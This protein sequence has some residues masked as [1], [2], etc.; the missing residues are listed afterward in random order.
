MYVAASRPADIPSVETAPEPR[1]W[2]LKLFLLSAVALTFPWVGFLGY[3]AY[4]FA[5]SIVG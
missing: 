1:P 5:D 4:L 3:L 2:L